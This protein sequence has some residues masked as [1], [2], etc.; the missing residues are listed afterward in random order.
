LL[1]L[2]AAESLS[3]HVARLAASLFFSFNLNI[4]HSWHNVN[5]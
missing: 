3:R 4:C 5:T 2:K 1:R